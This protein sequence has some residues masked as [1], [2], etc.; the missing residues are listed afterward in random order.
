MTFATASA[1]AASTPAAATL[2]TAPALAAAAAAPAAVA[3]AAAPPL[4]RALFRMRAAGHLLEA[5]CVVR[6]QLFHRGAY[7]GV[8]EHLWRRGDGVRRGRSCSGL[9]GPLA[10]ATVSLGRR[11]PA[12]SPG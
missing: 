7:L 1:L 11:P 4:S 12:N 9:L 10:A 3:P 5:L 6:V 2:A 8:L